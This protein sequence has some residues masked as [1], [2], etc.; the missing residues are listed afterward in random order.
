MKPASGLYK[1]GMSKKRGQARFSIRKKVPVPFFRNNIL[2]T[3]WPYMGSKE[4][5]LSPF[6]AKNETS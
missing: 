6:C 3:N 5:G 2:L 1:K 4:R